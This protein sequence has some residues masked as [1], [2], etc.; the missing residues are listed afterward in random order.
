MKKKNLPLMFFEN[1]RKIRRKNGMTCAKF[2]RKDFQ[3]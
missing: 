3:R 2:L 1:Q